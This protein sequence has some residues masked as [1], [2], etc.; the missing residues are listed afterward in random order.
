MVRISC[1]ICDRVK[2]TADFEYIL[3]HD[4]QTLHGFL[5]SVPF[6]SV[7]RNAGT[8]TWK[9]PERRDEVD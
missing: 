2:I 7:A 8:I 4:P 9:N 1:D 3:G 6:T 5:S